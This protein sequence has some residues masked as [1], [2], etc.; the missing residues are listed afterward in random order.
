M[1]IA[2][3]TNVKTR[4]PNNVDAYSFETLAPGI[5]LLVLAEGFG[6]VRDL[7]RGNSSQS[8]T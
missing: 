1:N 7:P 4:A 3:G 2:V 8:A 6:R 5:A